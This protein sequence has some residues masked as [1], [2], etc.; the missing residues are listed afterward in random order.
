MLSLFSR[1]PS[2]SFSYCL[3]IYTEDLCSFFKPLP[4]LTHFVD[5]FIF[6]RAKPR[7]WISWKP[8]LYFSS[9]LLCA[10]RWT[11]HG[12]IDME[13]SEESVR[14]LIKAVSFLIP[15]IF[16]SI[17]SKVLTAGVKNWM[18]CFFLRC[19]SYI[20]CRASKRYFMV[21]HFHRESPL[22]FGRSHESTVISSPKLLDCRPSIQHL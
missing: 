13:K 22:V 10:S 20:L 9:L 19:S 12:I 5:F 8:F 15:L 16:L 17:I 2:V 3:D 4:H 6:L 7:R 18:R 1:C 21:Y 11:M 14:R